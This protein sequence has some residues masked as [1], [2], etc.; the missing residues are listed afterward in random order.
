[1]AD[2][3]KACDTS[4][5]PRPLALGLVAAFIGDVTLLSGALYRQWDTFQLLML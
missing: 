3:R 4:P 1:M 2:R 5:R